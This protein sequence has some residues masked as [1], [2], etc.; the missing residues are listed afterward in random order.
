MS[1]ESRIIDHLDNM[2]TKVTSQQK[3]IKALDV[4]KGHLSTALG[5]LMQSGQVA[6]D[7]NRCGYKRGKPDFIRQWLSRPW[8]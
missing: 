1:L 3:L 7:V 5:R 6:Y 2:T 8:R 4:D